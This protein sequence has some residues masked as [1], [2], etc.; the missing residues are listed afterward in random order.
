MRF[1]PLSGNSCVEM[2]HCP[3]GIEGNKEIFTVDAK[4]SRIIKRVIARGPININRASAK[5]FDGL[6]GIG[7]VIAKRIVEY[8]RV[9]GPF[10][11]IE[12]L[13][14]KRLRMVEIRVREWVK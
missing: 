2:Y 10:M 3:H 7:P 14:N 8:R 11:A 12:D 4:L 5:E 6:V 1:L 13:Q 9:N